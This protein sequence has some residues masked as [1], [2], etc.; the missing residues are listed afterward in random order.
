MGETK[1]T[2]LNIGMLA[3]NEVILSGMINNTVT[4]ANRNYLYS[5]NNS[6]LMSPAYY[7]SYYESSYIARFS[8]RI[9]DTDVTNNSGIRPVI[10]VKGDVVVTGTGTSSN[11]YVIK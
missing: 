7:Q 1:T 9:S 2:E 5:E 8:D 4:A 10:N 6:W 11:P 3:T